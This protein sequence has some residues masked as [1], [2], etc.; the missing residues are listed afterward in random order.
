MRTVEQKNVMLPFIYFCDIL[1]YK[2]M[3]MNCGE[4]G[5]EVV[6]EGLGNT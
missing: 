3:Q 4:K 5:R 1:N 6:K 2:C